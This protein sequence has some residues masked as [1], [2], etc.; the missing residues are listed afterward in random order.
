MPKQIRVIADTLGNPT[1]PLK[2]F[3]ARNINISKDFEQLTGLSQKAFSRQ[4][5]VNA[6]KSR[7]FCI[8]STNEAEQ[9]SKSR[10]VETSLNIRKI[11]NFDKL[12]ATLKRYIPNIYWD[13][14][15]FWSDTDKRRTKASFLENLQKTRNFAPLGQLIVASPVH[16]SNTKEV[17]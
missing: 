6:C 14:R 4:Y 11:R 3:F 5:C 17:A 15:A 9:R 2:G 8:A 7:V 13:L 10:F 1:A 16:L 12:A